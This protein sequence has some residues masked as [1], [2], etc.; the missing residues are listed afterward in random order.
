M[1][2]PAFDF[3]ATARCQGLLDGAQCGDGLSCQRGRCVT[4]L[5]C[6]G[7]DSCGR[8]CD[9]APGCFLPC[10]GNDCTQTCSG[11][12][13]CIASCW[14]ADTCSTS[15]EQGAS[16]L[17]GCHDSKCSGGCRGDGT[18]CIYGCGDEGECDDI[19]C[20]DGA[21]CMLFCD[22]D[23]CSFREGDGC[24]QAPEYCTGLGAWVCG[25]TCA[26]A[27]PWSDY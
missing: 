7:E 20:E 12:G 14:D 9:S 4:T 13:H 10:Y 3:A 11:G 5:A 22:A 1:P 27:Q 8:V 26:E 25:I 15:C 19:V 21:V 24:E 16:C 2:P 17:V 23:E 18:L 6:E